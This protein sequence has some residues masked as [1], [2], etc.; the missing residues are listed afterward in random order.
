MKIIGI[1]GLARAGK[2]TFCGIAQNILKKNGFKPKQ[3]AFAT[4]LKNEVAPFLKEKCGVDIWT[5][6]S[7]EKS[8]IR[9]FLVWYGT[10][11][12]RKKQPKRWITE[13][14]YQLLLDKDNV[15]IAL[16]SDV[17]YPNEGEWIHSHMGYLI[18]I[19]AYK[20]SPRIPT[21]SFDDGPYPDEPLVKR[22]LEAPN[23]QEEINNPLVKG[24][25]DWKIEW[26]IR[27]LSLENA[28]N[29][30][31]LRKEVLKALNSIEWFNDA[32]SL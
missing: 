16:V 29:D 25:S 27:G 19:S 12:W 7:E 30:I 4:L 13:L 31:F 21:S 17:R 23:E 28:I 6:N 32:L 18:H 11:F 1:G 8:D 10:T 5:T 15:D 22:F 14:D 26:E 24:M 9:D 2:D 20:M 3:Y